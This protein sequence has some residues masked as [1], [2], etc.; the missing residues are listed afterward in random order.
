MAGVPTTILR[1]SKSA[2]IK[3][4]AAPY[5]GWEET[6]FAGGDYLPQKGDLV[7][8][9]WSGKSLEDANLSH[10]AIVYDVRQN[11]DTVTLTVIH[12]NCNN[13]V[14]I[15]DHTVRISDGTVSG[16]QVG[17]FAAPNY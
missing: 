14:M 10:T 6:V 5:H 8:F 11:A 17:Y 2:N 16:G 3:T 13:S 15:S 7:L 1:S 9:A 4:F 12:G